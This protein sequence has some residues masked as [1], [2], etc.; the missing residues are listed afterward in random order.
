MQCAFHQIHGPQ[1]G[2]QAASL[3]AA[4]SGPRHLRAQ[5]R[6]FAL[7]VCDDR[8]VVEERDVERAEASAVQTHS[9]FSEYR[10]ATDSPQPGHL[11]E[12][13]LLACA[14]A[15]RD[16][17]GYFRA[18]DLRSPL[19]QIVG[20]KLTIQQFQ[21]HLAELSA[22]RQTLNWAAVAVPSMA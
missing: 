14:Y 9:M 17:L 21:R 13:V 7:A 11:F 3:G 16:G 18:A 20:R 15:R 8:S 2:G 19:S 1:G 5:V 10:R 12:P 22:D 4:P 6:C